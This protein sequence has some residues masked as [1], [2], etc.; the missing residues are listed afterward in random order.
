M[1]SEIALR[2]TAVHQCKSKDS[3][4]RIGNFQL[5]PTTP[6]KGTGLETEFNQVNDL[7][8]HIYTM[9]LE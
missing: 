4:Q 1:G 3:T 9:N 6:G 2:M 7:I 5:P 8:D